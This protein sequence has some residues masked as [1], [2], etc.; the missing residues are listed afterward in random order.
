MN[1]LNLNSLCRKCVVVNTAHGV[2]LTA[3]WWT[4]IHFHMTDVVRRRW[5]TQISNLRNAINV[6]VLVQCIF[7]LTF[8]LSET[9]ALVLSTPTPWFDL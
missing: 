1:D 6:H 2:C 8:S 3:S 5:C 9:R 4:T 7:S